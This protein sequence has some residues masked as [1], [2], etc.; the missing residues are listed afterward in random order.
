MSQTWRRRGGQ[1]AAQ[2]SASREAT[3]RCSSDL[4]QPLL[5]A[6]PLDFISQHYPQACYGGPRERIRFLT[7]ADAEDCA[8]G[9]AKLNNELL[10]GRQ[11]KLELPNQGNAR[12]RR[13]TALLLPLRLRLRGSSLARGSKGPQAH[14]SQPALEHQ[15]GKRPGCIISELQGKV[16]YADLPQSKG[17]LS[18]S[19]FVTL[20]PQGRAGGAVEELNGEGRDGRTIAV[21]WAVDKATLGEGQAEGCSRS[22]DKSM[23]AAGEAV[24]A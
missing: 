18:G 13:K 22:R 8:E 15:D 1:C 5:Q 20:P 4:W 21:D 23:K 17:K 12:P 19:S 11:I 14:H 2:E 10:D 9:R 24:G 16:K 6:R 3:G 7:F